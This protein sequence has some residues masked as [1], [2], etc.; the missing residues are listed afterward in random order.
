MPHNIAVSE[1][2]SHIVVTVTGNVTRESAILFNTDAILAC[3]RAGLNRILVD[4]IDARNVENP[5]ENYLFANRDVF[6]LEIDLTNRVALLV[7]PGDHSHDFVET[8]SK[9]AGLNVT[10][11]RDRVEA[12]AFLRA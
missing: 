8:V 4:L 12:L 3:T 9:N 6:T 10:L 5:T 2:G 7:S 1:D 11:F